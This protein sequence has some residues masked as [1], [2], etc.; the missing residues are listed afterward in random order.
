M[1]P[2]IFP[3]STSGMPPS[4]G[5]APSTL[6][7]R[8]PNAATR[9]CILVGLGGPLEACGRTRLVNRQVDA[10]ELGAID[11]FKEHKIAVRVDDGD[12]HG[13]AILLRFGHGDRG[14]SLR[15]FQRNGGAVGVGHLCVHCGGES[16]G[17]HRRKRARMRSATR[18]SA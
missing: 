11:L 4:T 14:D 17:M 16:E 7:M 8:M 13:P 6:R 1:A 18:V 9:N 5:M 10:A 15:V 12:G 3:F 2:M